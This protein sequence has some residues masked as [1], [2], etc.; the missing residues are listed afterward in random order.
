M[1]P[2]SGSTGRSA[3]E[4]RPVH[5]LPW[6]TYGGPA[7]L[8]AVAP[9]AIN[10]GPSPG[11][12]P[13]IASPK[14]T[15]ARSGPQKSLLLFGAFCSVPKAC[16]ARMLTCSLKGVTYLP[17]MCGQQR[18]PHRRCTIGGARSRRGTVLVRLCAV[19]GGWA[20]RTGSV[21]I[22]SNRSIGE[23]VPRPDAA[24]KHRC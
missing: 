2:L 23:W 4:P 8:F 10:V 11:P 21:L 13:R 5:Q 6:L 14:L 20:L 9:S 7:Y 16:S 1:S 18:R 17:Q 24:N 15:R 12:R 3:I 22:T 19:E